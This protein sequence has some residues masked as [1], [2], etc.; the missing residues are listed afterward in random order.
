MNPRQQI[1]VYYNVWT[2]RKESYGGRDTAQCMFNFEEEDDILVK[3]FETSR[4]FQKDIGENNAI[5][6]PN[7]AQTSFKR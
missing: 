3:H 5:I 2:E 1:Y 7:V 6:V 4:Y